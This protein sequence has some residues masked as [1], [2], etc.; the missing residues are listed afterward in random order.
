[1]RQLKI[2]IVIILALVLQTS[3][4]AIP[5]PVGKYSLYIDLP[6]IV[7]VYFALQRD[8]IM[9]VVIGCVTGLAM[10]LLGGG[11]LG[12]FGFTKTLVAFLV[13]TVTTRVMLLDNPLVRIPVLAGAA[14]LDSALYV[15]LH[16]LFGQ[17]TAQPFVV[18]VTMKVIGTTVVGTAILYLLERVFSDRAVQR[19]Q[20][21]FRRRIARRSVARI[22]RRR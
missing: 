3:A 10:D 9:A 16:H 20:F 2:A 6:L 8:A 4:R 21:A 11:L 17:R 18:L 5:G 15:G 22:G 13:V 7:V 14:V 1:M 19:K 12:A